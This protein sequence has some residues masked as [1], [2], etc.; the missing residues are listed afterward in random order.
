VDL[1]RKDNQGIQN[2]GIEDSQGNITIDL[3]HVLKIYENYD[4]L[5]VKT[6]EEVD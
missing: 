3:R 6:G 1:D 2:F 5:E 4:N